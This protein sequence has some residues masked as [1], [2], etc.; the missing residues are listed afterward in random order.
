MNS[1]QVAAVGALAGVSII[2]GLLLIVGGL[3]RTPVPAP[4]PRTAVWRRWWGRRHDHRSLLLVGAAGGVAG[5]AL[6]GW[7]IALVLVPA[8]VV[9]LPILLAPQGRASGIAST[10][11]PSGPARCP[12][13]SPSGWAWSRP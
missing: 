5:F 13:C 4:R 8:A 1:A 12:G 6:T 9:G 10:R 7:V 2:G 3:R 11:W